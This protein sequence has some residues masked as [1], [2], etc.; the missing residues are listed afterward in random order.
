MYLEGLSPVLQK[1]VTT[2]QPNR[3]TQEK[4]FGLH[5]KEEIKALDVL[6]EKFIS[7]PGLTLPKIKEQFTLFTDACDRQVGCVLLQ[8]QKDSKD[9]LVG[10]LSGTLTEHE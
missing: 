2:F 3:E 10:C 1:Y 5:N 4:K 9:R 8:K 6:K 7:P